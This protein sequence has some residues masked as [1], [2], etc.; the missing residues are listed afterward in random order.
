[1]KKQIVIIHGGTSFKKYLDYILYLKREKISVE[2][3]KPKKDWKHS[4]VSKLKK[5]YEVLMPQ[6]PNKTNAKYKEWEIWFS[7]IAK[8]IN[9]NVILIGH[10]LGGIFLAKYLS[11]NTF[12]K[13]IKAT[14]L[15]A[16]PFDDIDDTD[17]RESLADFA[18]PSSLKKLEKQG[19]EIYLI[20]SQDDPI[21]PFSH[22]E[23]YQEALPKAK[24]IIFEDK[25]HFNQ[26]TFPEIIKLIK[27][28][29]K[30]K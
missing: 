6:M 9:N 13:K 14:I 8:I 10:S 27:S 2:K 22:L 1:M 11:K 15:V 26:E 23:K 25:Q 21:V 12:P 24:T 29:W 16:A 7:R 20:Y 5:N 18:L 4:L 17:G 19:G 3:L 28:V 30:Q